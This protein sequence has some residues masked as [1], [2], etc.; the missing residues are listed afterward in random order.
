MKTKRFLATLLCLLMLVSLFP[1]SALA[2][3]G[4][5]PAGLV[6]AAGETGTGTDEEPANEAEE[7]PGELSAD[8]TPDG[9]SDMTYELQVD[10]DPEDDPAEEP[11]EDPATEPDAEPMAEPARSL[12]SSV[13]SYPLWVGGV[14]VTDANKDNI[15]GDGTASF[16]PDSNTLTL[17]NA[18]ITA[19]S[20][21]TLS[22]VTTYQNVVHASGLDLTVSLSGDN[23]LGDGIGLGNHGLFRRCFALDIGERVV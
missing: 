14:Q 2:D 8:P 12:R 17:T 6:D 7:E 9:D 1:A 23:T 21:Y 3:D 11:A 4:P 19:T 10:G 5:A 22:S 13:M 20:T 16:D 18:N 15:L